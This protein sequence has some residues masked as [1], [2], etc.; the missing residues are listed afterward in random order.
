MKHWITPI[1]TVT[2]SS[3][4]LQGNHIIFNNYGDVLYS[5]QLYHPRAVHTKT[6]HP[7][8]GP[9]EDNN[10]GKGY[11]LM[12]DST[13]TIQTSGY[14]QL[15]SSSCTIY[16]VNPPV[17]VVIANT[18][19]LWLS[20]SSRHPMCLWHVSTLQL[21]RSDNVCPWCSMITW[22]L[23]YIIY[24]IIKEHQYRSLDIMLQHWCVWCTTAFC[25]IE[26]T[27]VECWNTEILRW[28]YK[29]CNL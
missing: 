18:I 9:L 26:R 12:E 28:G 6:E 11:S 19:I 3:N 25:D 1:S 24:N 22:L 7:S 2:L 14:R 4:H 8:P 13:T 23:L 17:C 16:M 20:C 21:V 5:R 27:M 10:P 15:T 29:Y